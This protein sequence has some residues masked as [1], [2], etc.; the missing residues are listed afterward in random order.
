MLA[1]IIMLVPITNASAKSFTSAD[2]V[3]IGTQYHEYFHSYF[4]DKISY[5]YFPYS[6]YYGSSSRTCYFGIDSAGN[7][8]DIKY[9]EY[10]SGSYNNYETYI[11]TGIDENF[12]VSGN[13]IINVSV[14]NSYVISIILVFIFVFL[15]FWLMLGVI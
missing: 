8:V 9:R 10:S 14:S 3:V 1:L 5:Q 15:I 13:N 12:S 4:G 6:C 7:Y 11:E 2:N